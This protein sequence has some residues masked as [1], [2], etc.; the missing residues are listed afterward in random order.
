M[1]DLLDYH[2]FFYPAEFLAQI[3]SNWFDWMELLT[4]VKWL[5]RF[6]PIHYQTHSFSHR[7]PISNRQALFYQSFQYFLLKVPKMKRML[8]IKFVIILIDLFLY[9][10]HKKMEVYLILLSLQLIFQF[11]HHSSV[12]SHEKRKKFF[13]SSPLNLLTLC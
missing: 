4:Q 1:N 2:K 12:K 9:W 5:Q 10:I 11:L 6:I 8:R 13:S 3:I 7:S